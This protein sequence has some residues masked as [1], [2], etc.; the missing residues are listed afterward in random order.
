MS[1]DTR[2]KANIWYA[3]D[4]DFLELK[5][6]LCERVYGIDPKTRIKGDSQTVG[7]DDTKLQITATTNNRVFL[8][9]RSILTGRVFKLAMTCPRSSSNSATGYNTSG[10]QTY[11][12]GGTPVTFDF[13]IG[14][15]DLADWDNGDV[16]T[17][18]QVDWAD[19]S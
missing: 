3:L 15:T 2:I 10:L 16:N 4:D 6:N 13:H 1:D 14:T 9:L 11:K 8:S 12:R 5:E 18:K 19:C 17:G 7:H